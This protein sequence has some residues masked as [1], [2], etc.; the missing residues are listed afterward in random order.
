MGEYRGLYSKTDVLLLVGV[1]EKFISTWLEN[2]G[3]GPFPYLSNPGLNWDVMLKMT[4][5][6]LELT[7]DIACICL[8]K[9]GWEESVLTL[10]K[11]IVKQIINICNQII[12]KKTTKYITYFDPN[13]SYGWAMV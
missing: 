12:I 2:H 10:L 13:N 5:I 8:L 6:Q 11:D 4:R 9:K 1:F 3:I 7:S